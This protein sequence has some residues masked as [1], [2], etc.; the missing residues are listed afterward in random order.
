MTLILSGDDGIT[1]PDSSVQAAAG[2]TSGYTAKAWVQYTMNGTP[3][4][5]ADGGLSSLTDLGTG[6]P[7]FTMS[8][9]LTS[10]S[11]TLWNIC[12]LYSSGYEYAV[13]SGARMVSST[14]WD[15]DCG[16]NVN[17]RND[18]WLGYSGL[19]R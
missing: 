12:G 15:G 19:I 4:I 8:N 13:Q 14:V 3:A 18:W 5:Q 7:R 11:A 17:T 6:V 1:F 10:A 9:A 16:S 2:L